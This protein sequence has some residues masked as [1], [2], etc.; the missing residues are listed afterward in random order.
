M[1]SLAGTVVDLSGAAIPGAQLKLFGVNGEISKIESAGKG[2]FLFANLPPGFY[3]IEASA[4]GLTS[5]G[6]KDVKV[7][8]GAETAVR[9][10]MEV[11]TRHPSC[12]PPPKV[13][14]D[15]IQS[16]SS[17]IAG[18]VE[19]P[20]PT[21]LFI[22]AEGALITATVGEGGK[23]VA[24]TRTDAAGHFK[25]AIQSPAMYTVTAHQDGYGDFIAE[26]IEARKGVRTTIQWS[27]LPAPCYRVHHCEP[28][29]DF[30]IFLYCI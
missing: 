6:A 11:F 28:T 17:E 13:V 27:L 22:P 26:G 19:V 10:V 7:T 25:L 18:R 20:G 23:P 5:K 3:S 1:G 14:F 2:Q 8:G 30:G 16:T 4:P 15:P 21:Y 24:S 29:R 12:G 9:I